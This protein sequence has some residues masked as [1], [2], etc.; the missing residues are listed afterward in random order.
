MKVRYLSL[1]C[2]SLFFSTTL[3][4]AQ[5]AGTASRNLLKSGTRTPEPRVQSTQQKKELTLDD[6][7]TPFRFFGDTADVQWLPDGQSYL[8]ENPAGGGLAKVDVATGR[9]TP[10][11]DAPRIAQGLKTTGLGDGEANGLASLSN[12]TF[13]AG[14]TAA[15]FDYKN[16][17][18][19]CD[20]T[21]GKAIRLTNSPDKSE[22][23][24][25]F[26]PDGQ[27]VAFVRDSN[28]FVVSVADGKERALTQ[29]GSEKIFNG[30]LDWVYEEE[31]YGRGTKR[32]YWWAPN[33]SGLAYLR[34][35]DT[36]VPPFTVIDDLVPAQKIE[37][38][39][40]PKVGDPNPLVK[41]GVASV[42]TGSTQ[43]MDLSAYQPIEFLITRVGWKPDSTSVVF[44]VQDRIQTWMDLNLGH[45]QSGKLQKLRREESKA[46]V[47]VTELPL[48]I[49]DGTFYWL[50]DRS[51]YRHLYHF[52]ADGNLINAVTKGNWDVRDF[53]G[54]SADGWAYF[55][56]TEHSSIGN[57]VYRIQTDGSGLQRLSN[58]DGTHA[59][60]FSPA[61]NAYVDT[62]SSLTKA[63]KS[64]LLS[65]NGTLIRTL[66][67]NKDNP[68]RE[69]NLGS[70][71]LL[72]VSTRDGFEMNAL[73][74]KPPDFD[75]TKKYPVLTHTYGGP[76]SPQVR[77]SWIGRWTLWHLFMAQKGYI[78]WICDNRSASNK[79]VVSAHPVYRNL[80]ELELR[81]LEDG[82]SYLKKLPYVDG[83][84]IGIWGWSYGGYMTAYA[85]THSTTFKVGI[86]GAPVT[87]WRNYDSIY[88]ERYMG[89]PKDNPE[90]YRKSSVLEAAGNLH[91]KLLL[92]HGLIDDNVHPQNSVQLIEALQK[93]GK[94]FDFMVYP[95][96]R[97]GVSQPHRVKHLQKL[98]T[99]FIT[100]NL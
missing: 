98:M 35:D 80:G 10:F 43:W 77:D 46:W 31:V 17:L 6:V 48:W 13:N 99:R 88:T 37:I 95:A 70:S 61:L 79:G 3:G 51:G 59:A 86:A 47:D 74:I 66:A 45:A 57:D 21:T 68:L 34:I 25:S 90:G 28:L 62:W 24:A 9:M 85:L 36:Q 89:L 97:H 19:A 23:E 15:L 75:P 7:A 22:L 92:I 67:E 39:N 54:V 58:Q 64:Q 2:L 49:P 40:Y 20:L 93:A 63:P 71:E 1:L 44:E 33:S 32:A 78:V 69:Y 8:I 16:D 4:I 83:G 82:V 65:N 50:S 14:Y 26:S 18:F 73:M 12:C 87:D 100:E 41:L 53:H 27:W 94:Q 55:S 11:H 30:Y 72:K 81:D 56:G 5:H 91:G 96:S 60:S 42:Q 29:D 84:R 76:G 52:G 38:T